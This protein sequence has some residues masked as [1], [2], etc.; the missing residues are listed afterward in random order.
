MIDF[1]FEVDTKG[2][3]GMTDKSQD[4]NEGSVQ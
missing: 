2:S 3:K 4:P 1:K